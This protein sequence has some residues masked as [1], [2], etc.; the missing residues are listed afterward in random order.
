MNGEKTNFGGWL[1]R[2]YGEWISSEYGKTKDN[3]KSSYPAN[4]GGF[5]DY[6]GISR[7]TF[8]KLVHHNGLPERNTLKSLIAIY[9][10]EVYDALQM[11]HSPVEVREIVD[12][13]IKN[14]SSCNPETQEKI[15]NLLALT[16]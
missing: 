3:E 10:L 5:C 7:P 1:M 8:A 11:E 16:E 12:L 14:W 9:G 6:L 2:K 13:V 15:R 4:K